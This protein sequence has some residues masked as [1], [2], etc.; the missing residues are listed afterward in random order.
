MKLTMAII[1][2]TCFQVSAKV[3]SQTRITLKLQSTELKKA[4][5]IIERKSSYRFLYNDETVKTGTKVD[6]EANN[7]PVT[8][9]LDKLFANRLLSYKILEN[10]LVV[11]TPKDVE[12]AP[13]KITG[14]VTSSLGEVLSG[15]SVK[16][17]GS[18]LGTQTDVNGTFSLTVPD[19]AILVF[20]YVGY[21]SQEVSVSGRTSVNISL[22]AST[23]KMDEV[24]VIGYGTA[25]KR[26]LTGSITKVLGKDV[27][28]K[29]NTNPVSS[30]QGKVAGLSVVNDGR[31][32]QA[33]DI[34][35]RGTVSIGSVHPL[36]VVNGIFNDN[37]DFLNPNDIESIEV[38]KDPSSLAIFGVKG[39]SGV[40]AITTK[41][42][43]SGQLNVNFNTSFGSKKLVDKIQLASG[44]QFRSIFAQEAANGLNDPDPSI[45]QKN[46]DFLNNE[47]PKW[48]GNTDWV[49]ALTRRAS[50]STTNLSISSATDKNKFYLSAGYTNDEGLVKHV[51]Y[52]RINFNIN[53]EVKVSNRLKFG[54]NMTVSRELLPYGS[55]ELDAARR[56]LPIINS[57]T[58]SIFAKNPYGKDSANYNIYEGVPVIQNTEHNPLM[59]V[60]NEWNTLKDTKW[61]FVPSVFGEYNITKDLSFRATVYTDMSFEDKR[62]YNPLYYS[63]IPTNT[64]G[65]T[66]VSLYNKT[67]SLE[68]NS[69]NT[70]SFQG[71]YIFN[72]RKKFGDHSFAATAGFTHY[73]YGFFQTTAKVLQQATDDPIPNDPRLW[74][75]SSGFGTPSNPTSAQHEYATVSGLVRVLY[76]YKSKYYINGSFRRDGASGIN[77]EYSKKFQNFWAI[78]AAWEISKEAFMD[79][80][81]AFNFLKLKGSIGV[82]G[83][84]NTL[85][86]DYP[87]Y[88]GLGY[89]NAQFGVNTV[90]VANPNYLV[91]PNLRWEQINGKEI[92][93]EFGAFNNRLHGEINY[94]DKRTKNLLAYLKPSGVS[95]T[96][97]NSGEIS[98]NGIELAASWNQKIT[99]DLSVTIAGNFTTY[100]NKVIKLNYPTNLDPQVPNQAKEGYPIGSFFGYV[101]DGIYQ[102]YNDIL[103]SPV[104]KGSGTS[105]TPGDFKYKDLNGDNQIDDRDQTNIGNP[106]PDFS[107]GG[108]VSFQYKGFDLGVDVGGVYGNEIYRYWGTSEQKNSVYNYPAYYANAWHGAGTSTTVPIVDAQHTVNRVPSTYAIEDGSYIR[109]RNLQLGYN[110]K[111]SVLSR[112]HIKNLRFFVNVQNLKTWKHNLGYSPEYGGPNDSNNAFSFGIDRGNANG[113]LPRVFTGG[114]NVTF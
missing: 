27:A 57:G 108:S 104:Y 80:Q 99:S 64:T 93:V 105:P 47:M 109:I 2:F 41:S 52:E 7:T 17:K 18:S 78:G 97:T 87:A 77:Q 83:N 6:V 71:D 84:F 98:N 100:K 70:R 42:A 101:V 114:L 38:L 46:T 34:R 72:Y 94:Y 107:Y 35:I 66:A 74:Y 62:D 45:G 76:N 11:I 103:K 110:V 8:E 4:L 96:L 22:V 44:D 95:P 33:P 85:G 61:R 24:V 15:V 81:H 20:S 113:A 59:V 49:D 10:N 43:K 63:Y 54:F 55:D 56:A 58:K 13:Q 9:V 68:Q 89:T 29:P 79:N 88:P 50:F 111:A 53:D 23:Q 67:T 60:E 106:T 32:G 90:T 19:D 73:Y 51:K 1:L 65:G 91:D 30:L 82:L 12:V 92:G 39:A 5:S 3:F 86:N 69:Y 14:K 16:V 25:S 28:D 75:I 31:P 48:T 112:A 21:V 26:D 102:S 40:I 36:Y 37:I